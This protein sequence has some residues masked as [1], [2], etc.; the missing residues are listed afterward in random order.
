MKEEVLV[1]GAVFQKDN[2]Y[3][4]CQRAEGDMEAVYKWE[5]PGGSVE[6]GETD[7]EALAREMMEEFNVK[8]NVGKFIKNVKMEYQ[9]RIININFYYCQTDDEFIMQDDHLNYEWV[10]KED[11]INYDF[12]PVDDVLI[13]YLIGSEG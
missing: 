1:V 11:F 7:E 13:K 3:F 6:N 8:T 5:F 4:I 2:R 10:L 12:A 9:E